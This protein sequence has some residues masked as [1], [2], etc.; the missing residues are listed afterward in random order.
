MISN[1]RLRIILL[2]LSFIIFS[3]ASA[4][5]PPPMPANL[6]IVP[7][8]NDVST[9]LVAFSGIWE[10]RWGGMRNTESIVVIE[11][12]N[13]QS[14]DII[15]SFGGTQPGY[16]NISGDV[17][18]GPILQWKTDKLPPSFGSESKD[19]KCPCL[20]TFEFNRKLNIMIGYMVFEAYNFKV[21]GDFKR[22][23]Y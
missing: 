10:G 17:L 12:I 22:R 2:S 8:S 23:P 14:A 21:R 4:S 20:F 6:E 13:N 7:P 18:P 11:K 16:V 15:F 3:C 5:Y 1:L 9:E 19:I